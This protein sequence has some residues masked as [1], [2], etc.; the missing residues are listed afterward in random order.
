MSTFA[1][2]GSPTPFQRF[3]NHQ[4]N[5]ASGFDEGL[6]DERERLPTHC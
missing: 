3:I 2:L 4:I 1:D 5:T 6:D